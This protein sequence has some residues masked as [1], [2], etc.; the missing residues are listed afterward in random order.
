MSR[1]CLLV[2]SSGPLWNVAA[3]LPWSARGRV[4]R[5][6]DRKCERLFSTSTDIRWILNPRDAPTIRARTMKITHCLTPIVAIP[7]RRKSVAER[8]TA[9]PL[10]VRG[11]FFPS[12]SVWKTSGELALENGMSDEHLGYGSFERFPRISMLKR[13][14]TRS[15]RWR[16]RLSDRRRRRSISGNLELGWDRLRSPSL[17]EREKERVSWKRSRDGAPSRGWVCYAA[18]RGTSAV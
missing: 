3:G 5:T 11:S 17:G 13:N 9:V 10:A 6:V 8:K 7:R 4:V 12:C 2:S 14:S 15:T 1:D 16:T 18:H